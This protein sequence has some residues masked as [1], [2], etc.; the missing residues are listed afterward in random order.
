MEW[1]SSYVSTW[2]NSLAPTPLWIIIQHLNI[3]HHYNFK[4]LFYIYVYYIVTW[5]CNYVFIFKKG[6]EHDFSTTNSTTAPFWMHP[7]W[8]LQLWLPYLPWRHPMHWPLLQLEFLLLIRPAALLQRCLLFL[9]WFLMSKLH[10]P[11]KKKHIWWSSWWDNSS[12]CSLKN[13]FGTLW[14]VAANWMLRFFLNFTK[15][16]REVVFNI[17]QQ[18]P[19]GKVRGSTWRACLCWKWKHSLSRTRFL[20][21]RW[22]DSSDTMA[23]TGSKEVLCCPNMWCNNKTR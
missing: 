7:H 4:D 23:N 8:A 16:T 20:V 11:Q 12:N 17:C 21:R 2:L 10:P 22:R 15:K 14:F 1:D 19:N 9:Q 3:Q 13:S 18:T 6:M 5:H